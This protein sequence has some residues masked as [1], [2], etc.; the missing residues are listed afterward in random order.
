MSISNYTALVIANN[1]HV[2]A[3]V[4]GP[5]KNGK[6]VG[7]IFIEESEESK[8]R[9]LLN[10]KPIYNTKE[11]ALKAM[12]ETIDEIRGETDKSKE[13]YQDAVDEK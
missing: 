9:P 13:E 8:Y 2:E 3:D 10:T 11:A 6:Y 12:Q 7:W 5:A 4:G 1:P